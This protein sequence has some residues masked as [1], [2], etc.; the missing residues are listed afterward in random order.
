MYAFI[1]P[2]SSHRFKPKTKSMDKLKSMKFN[3]HSRTQI[4]QRSVWRKAR[5]FS[6]PY[7]W[8]L[9]KPLWIWIKRLQTV[10]QEIGDKFVATLQIIVKVLHSTYAHERKYHACERA[11]TQTCVASHSRVE[12]S[13]MNGLSC[14]RT[15]AG[16]Q[17]WLTL[18]DKKPDRSVTWIANGFSS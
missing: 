13:K 4:W 6:E 3:F 17:R 1:A 9:W 10:N 5:I 16:L 2:S 12:V 15:S 14:K 8:N 7:R 11:D 18:L